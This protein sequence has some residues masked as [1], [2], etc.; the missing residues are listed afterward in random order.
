MKN[1]IISNYRNNFFYKKVS[2]H[3]T[4]PYL[5]SR[6]VKLWEVLIINLKFVNV[7]MLAYDTKN[8]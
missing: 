6:Q 3:R 7:L 1:I 2:A 4:I 5:R 8:L